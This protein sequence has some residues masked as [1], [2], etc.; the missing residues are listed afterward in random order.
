M[1]TSDCAAAAL[2]PIWLIAPTTPEERIAKIARRAQGFIYYVS[3]EGVTGMQA[4]VSAGIGEM[5]AR[6]RAYS[7]LPIA[8]GFGISN[9][10]QARRVAANAEAIVV[11]SAV[12][13][14]IAEHGKSSALVPTVAAFVHELSLALK[15]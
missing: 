5:T 15:S 8:V 6:I 13:T 11:G 12:V 2:C 10:E 9:A 4:E 3:R 14:R 7:P 1:N